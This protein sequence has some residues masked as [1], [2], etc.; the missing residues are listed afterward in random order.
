MVFIRLG[1]EFDEEEGSDKTPIASDMIIVQSYILGLYLYDHFLSSTLAVHEC[2]VTFTELAGVN[3]YNPS[4]TLF[5]EALDTG[6]TL[7]MDNH[8]SND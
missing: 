5:N 8:L 1:L 4:R 7:F 6:I 3:L 2:I